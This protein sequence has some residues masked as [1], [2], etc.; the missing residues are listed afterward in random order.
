M[1]AEG[2]TAGSGAESTGPDPA[3][4]A[5]P[6]AG[7]PPP[8]ALQAPPH[9]PRPGPA[10]QHPEG[11]TDYIQADLRDTDTILKGAAHTLD[12]T[13]PAS[14]C[15]LPAWSPS[16]SGA[17]PARSTPRPAAWSA[18][19]PSPANPERLT[20]RTGDDEPGRAV[21]VRTFGR[22]GEALGR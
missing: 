6:V 16:A 10:D 15:S 9:Q 4:S 20:T 3:R 11:Q 19:A 17:C 14:T 13:R 5:P 22:P 2:G 21:E 18:T 1:R 7:A 12:L 8:S